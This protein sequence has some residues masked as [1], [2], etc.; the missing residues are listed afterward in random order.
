MNLY[1][2]VLYHKTMKMSIFRWLATVMRCQNQ[3]FISFTF[4]T[5]LCFVT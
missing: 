1:C 4:C 5:G 2:G 3:R